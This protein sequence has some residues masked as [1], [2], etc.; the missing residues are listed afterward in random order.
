MGYGS[1]RLPGRRC[2]MS[3]VLSSRPG[4]RSLKTESNLHSSGSFM[5]CSVHSSYSACGLD[6]CRGLQNCG[7]W[8][9]LNHPAAPRPRCWQVRGPSKQGARAPAPTEVTDPC[10]A[11]PGS[12]KSFSGELPTATAPPCKVTGGNQLSLTQ[13][14]KGDCFI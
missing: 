13:L 14:L 2:F 10:R 4:C 5:M 7:L 1:R 3:R 6:E 9:A 8:T 11:A 12:S